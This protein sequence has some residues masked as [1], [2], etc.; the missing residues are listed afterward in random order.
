MAVTETQEGM[1]PD[2]QYMKFFL[3]AYLPW[4]KKNFDS[5]FFRINLPHGENFLRKNLNRIDHWKIPGFPP[6]DQLL[7]G[8]RFDDKKP[9][10]VY[11]MYIHP[12]GRLEK[13]I[14]DL[15]LPAEVIF[16][17][18]DDDG[19]VCFLTKATKEKIPFKV[20]TPDDATDF[21]VHYC[22]EK[23]KYKAKAVS[24]T[25]S[26][27]IQWPT[28]FKS[29]GPEVHTIDAKGL[30][31]VFYRNK[32]TH[33]GFMPK[34][35]FHYINTHGEKSHLPFDKYSTDGKGNITVYYP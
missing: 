7:L 35:F 16:V 14:Q 27:K 3:D 8:M 18:W 4:H 19:D 31:S 30:V 25:T 1:A 11:Q 5:S 23:G 33:V 21:L 28:P 9:S 2:R 10:F 29:H 34:K 17:K 13:D 32:F 12:E 6:H 20:L 15:E 26:K 24:F 22:K